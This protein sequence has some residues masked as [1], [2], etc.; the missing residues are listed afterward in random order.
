MIL[1]SAISAAIAR[2]F[3]GYLR[4]ESPRYWPEPVP[5]GLAT[6]IQ[7]SAPACQGGGCVARA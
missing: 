5:V 1:E 2:Y 3:A 6:A 4:G 7:R